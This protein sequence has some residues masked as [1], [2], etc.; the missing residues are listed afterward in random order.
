MPP[1]GT[2]KVSWTPRGV[3]ET[4]PSAFVPVMTQGRVAHRLA[5]IDGA[6]SRHQEVEGCRGRGRLQRLRQDLLRVVL[7]THGGAAADEQSRRTGTSRPGHVLSW[8][9]SMWDGRHWRPRPEHIRDAQNP[10]STRKVLPDAG[11]CPVARCAAVRVGVGLDGRLG[12]VDRRRRP[13]SRC[14]P[15]WAVQ[16]NEPRS[17]SVRLVGSLTG[18]GRR[19][20]RRS[21][22]S[23]NGPVQG[24][25]GRDP[26]RSIAVLLTVVGS[27]PSGA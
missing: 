5:E 17:A 3:T 10:G 23:P 11:R 19:P 14:S 18:V 24:S 27:R 21:D 15:L 2:S 25:Q 7:G 8:I 13:P 1:S 4:S 22:S 26:R 12:R 16:P 20:V 6:V 9:S